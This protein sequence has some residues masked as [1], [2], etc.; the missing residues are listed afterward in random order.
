[1]C[2]FQCNAPNP[3]TFGIGH[4][5]QVYHTGWSHQWSSDASACTRKIL[6]KLVFHRFISSDMVVLT[7]HTLPYIHYQSLPYNTLPYN[8]LPYKTL[9]Y[10]TV[11]YIAIQYISIHCSTIQYIA[12]RY[13]AIQYIINA[14]PYNKLP[15]NKWPYN[16]LQCI[17]LYLH[18]HLHLR[19]R[20]RLHFHLYFY[21]ITLHRFLGG[22]VVGNFWVYSART[23][24]FSLLQD[25]VMVTAHVGSSRIQQWNHIDPTHMAWLSG[26]V[27]YPGHTVSII[28]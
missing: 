3:E 2:I 14:L 12:I 9:L 15:F 17:T 7:I 21:Y 13:I 26:M 20:L 19:W 6:E 11:L 4:P 25:H 5:H 22:A 23:C 24:L 18:S 16:T 8:T 28:M 27:P 1:M 10:V